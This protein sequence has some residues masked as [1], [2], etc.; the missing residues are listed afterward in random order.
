MLPKMVLCHQE[1]DQKTRTLEGK[2]VDE[3]VANYGCDG[4]D[5]GE[6]KKYRNNDCADRCFFFR[7]P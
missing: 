1:K 3:T 6:R 7:T 2:V 5:T 4:A